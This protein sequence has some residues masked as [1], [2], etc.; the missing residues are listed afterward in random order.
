MS[1]QQD[2]QEQA[3]TSQDKLA[4]NNSL[5]QSIMLNSFALGSFALICTIIIALT[6]I[7]TADN[8]KQQKKLAQLKAL[9]QIV[10][11]NLHDNDL[12]TDN[13]NLQVKQLGHRQ[14]QTIYL[15]KQHGQPTV[16]V[17]PV[18]TTDGY[19]GDISYIIGVNI[20]DNSIAGVRVVS[21]Q[22]TPGLG[23]KIELR[24]S[25][26]ILSFNGLS[27][28]NTQAEDWTVKKNG[29]KFD[30]FTGATITP[31]S[32]THSIARTLNYHQLFIDQLLKKITIANQQ[33]VSNG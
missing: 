9:Y 21:H 3:E 20:A 11:K 29:G 32:V 4:N 13:T 28:E 23:D 18:T 17:Y 12:L 30:G 24:K 5:L 27:L 33:K 15:A 8:I 19:S 14:A 2:T 10:P 31:R 1:D 26:W 25:P 6:Y 7:N 22:E 16:I